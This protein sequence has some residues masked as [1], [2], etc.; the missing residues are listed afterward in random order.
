MNRRLKKDH[1]GET[2]MRRMLLA[3]ALLAPLAANAACPD[4]AAVARLAAALTSG[5]PA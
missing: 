1:L 2:A 4:D 5:Q 3:C